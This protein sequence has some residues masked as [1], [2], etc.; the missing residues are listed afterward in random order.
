MGTIYPGTCRTSYH[1]DEF[2]IRLRTT[3]LPIHFIDLLQG[4]QSQRLQSESG[5]FV[6]RR[7]DGLIAYHLAVVIDDYDQGISEIVRGIDLLDSTPR[8][9]WLQQVLGF[10]QPSYMHI[11]VALN[12]DAKKLSKLTGA[13]GLNTADP[14]PTLVAAMAALRQNPPGSLYSSSINDIWDWTLEHWQLDRLTGL[15]EI[16]AS[17]YGFG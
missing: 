16:P 2:A 5:D 4:S 11:P 7:R 15:R 9:L 3:E 13:A 6:I 17:H 8:H 14:G 10:E 12:H 1:A